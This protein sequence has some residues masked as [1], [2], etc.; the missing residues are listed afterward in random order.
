MS[1]PNPNSTMRSM[2]TGTFPD[3][4]LSERNPC[5]SSRSLEAER[6][7][8]LIDTVFPPDEL[9]QFIEV[10][11]PHWTTPEGAEENGKFPEQFF[12]RGKVFRQFTAR[13]RGE[14]EELKPFIR[15]PLQLQSKSVLL[16]QAFFLGRRKDAPLQPAV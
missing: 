16:Q 5:A 4:F 7:G 12:V 13:R 11:R 9:D 14:V 2:G 3:G 10:L 8:A 6:T 15:T 1:I